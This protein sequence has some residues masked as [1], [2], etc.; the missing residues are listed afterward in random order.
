DARAV[1]PR[2]T[3]RR[4][5]RAR[6]VAGGSRGATAATAAASRWGPASS[7]NAGAPASALGFAVVLELATAT[8]EIGDAGGIGFEVIVA[9][10]EVGLV[11]VE[12]V[13][14]NAAIV[15]E[16]VADLAGALRVAERFRV[17]G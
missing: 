14:A 2:R 16:I 17:A 7:R 1:A 5:P 12:F 8:A 3:D 10:V 6:D 9:A 4:A 15:V 13:V 11:G